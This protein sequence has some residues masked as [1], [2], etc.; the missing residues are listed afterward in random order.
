MENNVISL[1]KKGADTKTGGLLNQK[2]ITIEKE[3]K[4]IR[5]QYMVHV[6]HF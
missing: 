5:M 1:I 3:S 6:K 2:K 4:Q